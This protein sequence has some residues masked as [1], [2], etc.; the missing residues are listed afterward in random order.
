M[1]SVENNCDD[2]NISLKLFLR[3]KNVY[4][5]IKST[6]TGG[7]VP[8]F[9]PRKNFTYEIVKAAIK[10]HHGKLLL[11]KLRKTQLELIDGSPFN[12]TFP[13]GLATSNTSL[14]IGHNLWHPWT[15]FKMNLQQV[16][17]QWKCTEKYGWA[18]YLTLSL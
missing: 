13:I 5:N 10:N 8:Q 1:W 16:L 2:T 18:I 14:E 6:S 4:D 9:R 17:A 15:S 7:H 11:L 12:Y 3:Y